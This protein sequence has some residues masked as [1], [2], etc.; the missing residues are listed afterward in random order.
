MILN[1]EKLNPEAKVNPESLLTL[2]VENLHAVTHLQHPTCLPLQYARDF[3]HMLESAKRMVRWSAYYFTQPSSYYPVPSSQIDSKDLP[4]MEP[5]KS[6]LMSP[7]DKQ[8]MRKWE[9]GHGKC[10]TSRQTSDTLQSVCERIVWP[11][12]HDEDQNV[13]VQEKP[14]EVNMDQASEYDTESDEE[15]EEDENVSAQESSQEVGGKN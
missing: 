13:N 4:R 5:L 12:E 15:P 6:P 14:A 3:K 7:E 8:L 10:V 1:I 9:R 2:K 11:S